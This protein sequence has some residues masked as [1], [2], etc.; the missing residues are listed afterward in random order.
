MLNPP[1]NNHFITNYLI[2]VVQNSSV[3]ELDVT[4]PDELEVLDDTKPEVVLDDTKPE[5]LVLDDTR[6]EALVL[7]DTVVLD[8]TKPDD[9]VVIESPNQGTALLPNFQ[10]NY[11]EILKYYYMLIVTP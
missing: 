10:Y 7:D 5:E 3:V 1:L 2:Q 9:S 6:P 8:D 11:D 4:D